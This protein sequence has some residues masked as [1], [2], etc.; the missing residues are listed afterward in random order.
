[1]FELE[2]MGFDMEGRVEAQRGACSYVFDMPL[3]LREELRLELV[4]VI[5]AMGSSMIE[6]NRADF[7]LLLFKF[8]D[9]DDG[10]DERLVSVPEY[11]DLGRQPELELELLETILP[12]GY[13]NESR[14]CSI[15]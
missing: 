3:K 15:L 9:D 6:E 1:M 14:N 8:D 10:N 5:G 7:G 4:V 11:T 13:A 12:K 2:T